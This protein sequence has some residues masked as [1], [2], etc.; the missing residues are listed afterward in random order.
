MYSVYIEFKLDL[1][2][3][4]AQTVLDGMAAIKAAMAAASGGTGYLYQVFVRW[5]GP[6]E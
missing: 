3:T 2:Q 5:I 4:P 1:D 6:L